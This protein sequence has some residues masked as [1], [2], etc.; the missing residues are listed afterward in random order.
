MP[1]TI[2]VGDS[3]KKRSQIEGTAG[4]S[5]KPTSRTVKITCPTPHDSVPRPIRLHERR[6]RPPWRRATTAQTK[7]AT[8]GVIAWPMLSKPTQDEAPPGCTVIPAQNSTEATAPHT[9]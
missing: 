1:I 3:K 9:T 6:V 8:S 4:V 5:P 7:A 2:N